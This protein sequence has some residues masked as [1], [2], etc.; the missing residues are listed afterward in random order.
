MFTLFGIFCSPNCA[1]S[2]LFNN[3][4]FFDNIWDKYS[5]LNLL[6]YK[7]YDKIEEIMLSPSKLCLKKFGGILTI[8]EFREKIKLNNKIFTMKFP[9]TISIIPVMEE[10]SNE[11]I[12]IKQKNNY[13]PIDKSRIVKANKEFKLKRT[14]PINTNKNTLDNCM[15]I[16][17]NKIF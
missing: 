17:I 16:T 3:D 13:I 10:I 15:N 14:K 7:I 1:A 5:L 8:E 11:K 12:E 6:Y 4:S 2:Y 9:P